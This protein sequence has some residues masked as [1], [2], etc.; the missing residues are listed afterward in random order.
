MATVTLIP[1]TM[2]GATANLSTANYPAVTVMATNLDTGEYVDIG[3]LSPDGTTVTP[4]SW[5]ARAHALDD[6]NGAVNVPGGADYVITLS[7]TAVA[8]MVSFSPVTHPN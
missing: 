2:A 7:A 1:A 5:D 6:T 3:L 8:S 4:L